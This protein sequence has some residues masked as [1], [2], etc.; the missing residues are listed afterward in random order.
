MMKPPMVCLEGKKVSRRGLRG[1]AE[2]RAGA[3]SCRNEAPNFEGRPVSLVDNIS[4]RQFTAT[5]QSHPVVSCRSIYIEGMGIAVVYNEVCY[6]MIHVV[7]QG[8]RRCTNTTITRAPLLQDFD[9]K[10]RPHG[11]QGKNPSVIIAGPPPVIIGEYFGGP[12]EVVLFQ[13]P[14]LDTLVLL[15]HP[16]SRGSRSP[17]NEL[18][19]SSTLLFCPPLLA[20]RRTNVDIFGGLVKGWEQNFLLDRFRLPRRFGEVPSCW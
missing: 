10:G 6:L 5:N 13:D 14:V 20:I 16:V 1:R 2:F 7:Q 19:V 3:W 8:R 17:P 18:P 4:A 9:W 12:V 15:T 11:T